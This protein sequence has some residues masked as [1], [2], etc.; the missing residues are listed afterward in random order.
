MKSE[1]KTLHFEIAV[2]L[3]NTSWPWDEPRISENVNFNLP[4]ALFDER[5]F[6]KL[7]AEQIEILKRKFPQ[8]VIDYQLQKEEE[9]KKKQAETA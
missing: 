1:I 8:A 6:A 3:N 2:T 9:E 4:L 5:N 7:M